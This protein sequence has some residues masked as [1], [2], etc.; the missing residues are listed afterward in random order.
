MLCMCHCLLLQKKGLLVNMRVT[1][2][3][4]Y[5]ELKDKSSPR[6]VCNPFFSMPF[7]LSMLFCMFVMC[8]VNLPLDIVNLMSV[9]PKPSI[10][11]IFQFVHE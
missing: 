11:N 7:L 5:S 9:I 10:T 8:L 1:C 3:G 4:C 6:E 2:A